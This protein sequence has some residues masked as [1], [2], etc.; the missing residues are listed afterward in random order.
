MILNIADRYALAIHGNDLVLNSRENFLMFFDD[1]R[2]MFAI[3]VPGHRNFRFTEFSGNCLLA[4]P[5]SSVVAVLW[6]AYLALLRDAAE[7]FYFGSEPQK[8]SDGR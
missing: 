6:A 1:D 8:I 2:L 3:S 4:V 5:V 7:I